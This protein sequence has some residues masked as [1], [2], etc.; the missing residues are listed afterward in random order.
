MGVARTGSLLVT[1]ETMINLSHEAPVRA[2]ESKAELIHV[3]EGVWQRHRR[4]S[5]AA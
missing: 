2:A 5:V 1:P 4:G 3:G